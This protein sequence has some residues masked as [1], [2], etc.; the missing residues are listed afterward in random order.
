MPNFEPQPFTFGAS[1]VFGL[2]VLLLGVWSFC[3][4]RFFGVIL[5]VSA[6]V[7]LLL[8][9]FVRGCCVRALVFGSRRLQRDM[10]T[11]QV[12]ETHPPLG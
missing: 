8:V 4:L 2:M 11:V 3:W 9:R 7:L 6:D 1:F 12:R 10:Q 5:G